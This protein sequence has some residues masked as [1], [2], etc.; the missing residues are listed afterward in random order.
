MAGPDCPSPPAARMRLGG[1]GAALALNVTADTPGTDASSAWAPALVPS[2][3]CVAAT[4]AESGTTEDAETEPAPA[5]G[6]NWTGV[7]AVGLPN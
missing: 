2:V 1:P 3:H 4:P 5:T 6:A 7:A